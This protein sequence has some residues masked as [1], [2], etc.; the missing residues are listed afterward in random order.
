MVSAQYGWAEDAGGGCV[1]G[2]LAACG[3]GSSSRRLSPRAVASRCEQVSRQLSWSQLVAREEV[4]KK[5]M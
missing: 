4:Q 5:I 2:G 3:N 1:A